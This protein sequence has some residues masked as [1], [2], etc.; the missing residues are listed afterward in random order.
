MSPCRALWPFVPVVLAALAAFPAAPAHA[1]AGRNQVRIPVSGYVSMRDGS[2]SGGFRITVEGGPGSATTDEGGSFTIELPPGEW[3]LDAQRDDGCRGSTV[4]AASADTWAFANIQ[5]GHGSGTL[6][7]KVLF[8]GSPVGGATVQI[9]CADRN[10]YGESMTTTPSGRYRFGGLE[11]GTYEVLATDEAGRR[12]RGVPVAVAAGRPAST[13]LVV[14]EGARISGRV[15][16]EDGSGIPDASVSAY[17]TDGAPGSTDPGSHASSGPDGSFALLGLEEGGQYGISASAGTDY[18]PANA[19]ADVAAPAEGVEVVLRRAATIACSVVG[20][21]GR[22]VVPQ[23]VA[24]FREGQGYSSSEA[25]ADGPGPYEITSLEPGTYRVRV[26][27]Q[28]L[29]AGW[30]DPVL[31]AS[32]QRSEVTVR[33]VPG[34]TVRGRVL[35]TGGQPVAGALVLILD[36]VLT[37]LLGSLEYMTPQ[38]FEEPAT[39]DEAVRR[40]RSQ[41]I[42]MSRGVTPADGRFTVPNVGAGAR[43]LV[44]V[45]PDYPM[46]RQPIEV[47]AQ[48]SGADVEVRLA[49]GGVVTGTVRGADG[50]PVTAGRVTLTHAGRGMPQEAEVDGQGRFRFAGLSPG[51]YVLAFVRN[52]AGVEAR[53]AIRVGAGEE[54]TV[55]LAIARGVTV[56][57]RL[58]DHGEPVRGTDMQVVSAG[59][60]FFFQSGR[61]VE[62][63]GEGRFE[64]SNIPPG[65]YRLGM[66]R[67]QRLVM[68]PLS[69]ED[70][71]VVEV[72]IE[73]P[74]GR[75]SGTIQRAGG[76]ASSGRTEIVALEPGEELPASLFDVLSRLAGGDRAGP[77]GSFAIQGLVPGRAYDVF[78]VGGDAVSVYRTSVVAAEGGEPLRM[79]LVEGVAATVTVTDPAGTPIEADVAVVDQHGAAVFGD[80][81]GRRTDA[82]GVTVIRVAAGSTVHIY[83]YGPD[84]AEGRL[85][86]Q[87]IA[88]G[89]RLTIVIPRPGGAAVT[90]R[91]ENGAAVEGARVRFLRPDGDE[92]HRCHDLMALVGLLPVTDAAGGFARDDLAPGP[93]TVLVEA[94]DGRTGVIDPVEVR[95]GETAEVEVRL[96]R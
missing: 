91:D 47:P 76:G 95:A 83:A 9:T 80:D 36:P 88:G 17:R 21:G 92:A 42:E 67:D 41:G 64:L 86:G 15:V 48:G 72:T 78:A 10:V 87:T 3:V 39:N 94:R 68:L 18:L 89:E 66:E 58:L 1:Q 25:F 31:V 75:I 11:D 23:Q 37:G 8:E 32:G 62:T 29:A 77:D 85:R 16:G 74:P 6:E 4:I 90:V 51:M 63:D 43:L 71:P 40:W 26:V 27:A 38:F 45:H 56:R 50:N 59:A 20:P 24:A 93:Y 84:G 61:R 46:T 44:A 13:D 69:V 60:I 22:T 19:S 30:S 7:G 79:E 14:T 2:V 5:A 52:E 49:R 54:R 34:A 65:V 57:G 53:A 33:L 73:I 96:P 82:T 55:D 70:R 28:G 12:C 35:D 81:P